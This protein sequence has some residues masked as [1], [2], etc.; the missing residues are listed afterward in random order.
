MSRTYRHATSLSRQAAFA[1]ACL[2]A[3][4]VMSGA[5]RREDP[6]RAALRGRLMQPGALS[7]AELAQVREEVRRTVDDHRIR[8]KDATGTR[9]LTTPERTVVLGMLTEPAGMFDE[10]LREQNGRTYRILNAPGVSDD[11]EIEA[12]R[13][14]WIDVATFEPR[15]FAFSY[16]V[17]GRGDYAFDLD[18]AR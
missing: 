2:A 18:I 15:R 1:L 14:L 7:T 13:R 6:A 10:G 9:D 11:M 3:T 16:A 4:A 5:C 12:T 17:P 8:A